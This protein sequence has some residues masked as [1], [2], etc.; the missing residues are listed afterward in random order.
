MSAAQPTPGQDRRCNDCG[1]PVVPQSTEPAP[2]TRKHC[3]RG[4]CVNCYARARARHELPAG[5]WR[6]TGPSTEFDEVAVQR[7]LDGS[8][9]TTP[10]SSEL[11]AAIDYLDRLGHSARRIGDRLG[12]T[13]RTVQRRRAARRAQPLEAAS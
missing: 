8:L 3:A 1:I 10:T 4:L 9:M 12:C 6:S 11:A 5:R 13:M 7:L 2:G